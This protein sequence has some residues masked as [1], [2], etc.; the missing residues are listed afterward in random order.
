MIFDY[1]TNAFL[2]K[3]KFFYSNINEIYVKIMI[4]QLTSSKMYI[5]SYIMRMKNKGI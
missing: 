2:E 4:T 1:H 3:K 5:S